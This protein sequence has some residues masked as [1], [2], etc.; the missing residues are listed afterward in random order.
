M[1]TVLLTLLTGLFFQTA[2]GGVR[3]TARDESGAVIPGVSITITHKATGSARH[4][5]SD[6]TGSYLAP[7]LNPGAYEV[8]AELASFQT[9]AQTVTVLTGSNANADF[10]LKVG[11]ASEVIQVTSDTAQVNLT[12]YKIDGVVTREQIE[13]LPLNGRSFLELAQLEPGVEVQSV[14]NPGTSANSYTRVSINGVSGALTRISVDG[15]T[16]NDRVTGGTSQNFSQETVQEF[17]ISTFN[18]DL[19]TS[20]TG[21]GSVNVVSRTGSN[22]IHG[23]GFFFFRDHNLS[24]YP[25][26]KRDPRDPDPFFARRQSGF[27]LGGPFK[28]DKLFWFTNFEHNN[29]MS[30]R[31]IAHDDPVFFNFDHIGQAPLRGKLFNARVDYKMSDKHSAFLRYSQDN[32]KNTSASSNLESSWLFGR[33]VANQALLSVTSV[34][35]PRVVNDL[36]YSFQFFSNH[37]NPPTDS[38]CTNAVGCIG[39]GGP[40]ISVSGTGFTIGNNDQVPQKRLLRT[41]QLTDNVSWQR[42]NQRW[43]FGGEWEH[44]YGSGSWGLRSS[45]VFTLFGPESVRVNNPTLY[46]ALP[47]TLRTTTAGTPSLQDILQLPF[48]NLSLGV[49]DINQPPDFN[50][51]QARRNDRYRLFFQDTWRIRPRFTL[52]FGLAWS[53]EDNLLNYDL[54]KPEYLRPVLG[55]AGADLRPPPHDYNNFQPALGFAWAI[56][57]RNKTVIR[58]GAGI[59]HDSNLFFSRLR[60]RGWIGPAGNGLVVLAGSIVANPFFGQ[61]GQPATLNFSTPTTTTGQQILDYLPSIRSALE[62]RVGSKTDLSIR[63]AEVF[64]LAGSTAAGDAIFDHDTTTAYTGHVTFGV[65]RELVRNMIVQADFVMRR[66]LHFGGPHSIF[67]VDMN[68]YERRKVQSIDPVTGAVTSVRDPVIPLCG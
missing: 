67:A 27:T 37:L 53:F 5:I 19:A 23:S 63:G 16:V 49:G 35:T 51:V 28:R 65:Q 3:G 56:D 15:A 38:D 12:D 45:G 22:D 1:K 18:F 14:D 43:R 47:A 6:E 26:F 32:N 42:G 2:T 30:V 57:R 40:R 44:F 48:A 8:K 54:D 61:P 9:Q 60:E 33:N 68:R 50:G 20:V 58:G 55:G 62:G 46:N 13:N 66:G 41:Y 24:A 39:V 25:G 36:R 21:I 11:A 17:Q 52:S 7:N 29:Q 10:K 59:Y 31:T 4:T 64:K 34:L